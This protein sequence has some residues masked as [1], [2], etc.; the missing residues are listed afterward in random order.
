LA[1]RGRDSSKARKV[2]ISFSLIVFLPLDTGYR[3]WFSF[4]LVS[5]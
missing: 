1:G 4:I 5:Y 2:A 3:A